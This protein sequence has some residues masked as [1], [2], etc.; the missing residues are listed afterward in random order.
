MVNLWFL[1]V[2]Q[3]VKQGDPLSPVLF[4]IA[5]EVMSRSLNSLFQDRKFVGFGLPKW[6]PQ[7][8]HLS[9]ADDTILFESGDRYSIKKMVV[10]C[11]S[12]NRSQVSS[13]TR[14]RV[15]STYMRIHLL[16]LGLG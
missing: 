3:R 8:N 10:F 14:I 12:M 16:G 4:I 13:L 15:S 11:V 1:S 6:S 2:F 5:A 7:I 9:Y